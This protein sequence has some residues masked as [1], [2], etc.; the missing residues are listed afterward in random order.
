[1]YY[2]IIF[3]WF[4]QYSFS[5][6]PN[7]YFCCLDNVWQLLVY[8]SCDLFQLLGFKLIKV[9]LMQVADMKHVF[10]Q[11]QLIRVK[12]YFPNC[13]KKIVWIE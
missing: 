3:L 7:D 1:M 5:N 12:M 4:L 11:G 13:M 2:I 10:Y 9:K 6:Q 8:S